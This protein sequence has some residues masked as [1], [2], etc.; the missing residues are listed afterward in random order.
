MK[1]KN[2]SRYLLCL[3]MVLVF[4]LSGCS[5]NKE[6][7]PEET[8]TGKPVVSV[9]NDY[10]EYTTFKDF[11]EFMFKENAAK[12]TLNLHYTLSDPS[13]YGIDDYIIQIADA[14][15]ELIKQQEQDLANY[16]SKLKSFDYNSLSEEEKL[17]YDM[18]IYDLELE[19]DYSDFYLYNSALSPT[20]GDNAQLPVLLAEY[21][22][23]NET[24]VK[25]YIA[26]LGT[27]EDYFKDLIVLEN[28]KSENG[29]FMSDSCADSIISQ[30]QEFIS[31]PESN[32]LIGVFDEKIDSMNDL[33]D[34]AKANYKEQNKN[35]VLSSVIPAYETLINSLSSLKGSGINASGLA[36]LENG[37]EYYKYLVSTNTGSSKSV[38]EIESIIKSQLGSDLRDIISLT[39]TNSN[40]FDEL[41]NPKFTLSDPIEILEDLQEKIKADFPEGPETTYEVKY[42]NKSLEDNI[43]PAFYLTPPI[44]AIKDNVIYINGS[45]KYSTMNLYPTLA[46]EGYPGHLYQVTYFSNTEPMLVRNI[47]NYPG[48]VEGWATYVEMI[49]YDYSGLESDLALALKLNSSYSLAIYCLVDIGVNYYAWDLD[50][51]AKFLS[52]YS[53]TEEETIKEIFNAMV[54]EP[55]NYLSYYVG[56]LEFMELRNY[57]METLGDD[58]DLKEFH[59]QILEIGPAPFSIIAERLNQ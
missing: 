1:K 27:L 23:G 6:E 50:A 7:T 58:F 55:A 54:A 48:Y 22:F 16:I 53:I 34:A 33:D 12:S 43:S 9:N 8:T 38:E 59:K 28:L 11:T 5:L 44:D 25:N 21:K 3:F 32:Y 29:L 14:S 46:H 56:Y 47:L 52:G 40:L 31:E 19:Q 57:S 41:E 18:L 30:C 49:S 17:T 37:K 4:T 26:L 36:G 24:D 45:E 20:I 2:F 10:S 15:L 39:A 42:V 13:K 35:A 51:T